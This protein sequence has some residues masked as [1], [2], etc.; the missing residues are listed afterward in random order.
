MVKKSK[1]TDDKINPKTQE[2]L[3]KQFK[4]EVEKTNKLL[5]KYNLIDR[6]V[7]LMELW[8]YNNI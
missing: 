6:N 5:Y 4:T 3:K 7:D 1:K 2:Q 8:S